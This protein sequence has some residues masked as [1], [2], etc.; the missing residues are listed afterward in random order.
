[1]TGWDIDVVGVYG[2]L[3]QSGAEARNL[4]DTGVAMQGNLAEAA[5]AAGT[6]TSQLGPYT[7]TAGPV[8][9]ALGEF[10]QRWSLDL[11]YVAERASRSLNGAGEAVGHYVQG[12]LAMAATA[13]A[14]AAKE[15]RLDL[16]GAGGTPGL[17]AGARE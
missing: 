8:G 14:E 15:P 6:I 7:S 4:S 13:Q 3:S 9:A 5:S 12:D 10:L 1:M 11:R 16:P 17:R 2:V